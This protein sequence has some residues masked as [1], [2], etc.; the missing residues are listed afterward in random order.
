MKKSYVT[1]GAC[2]LEISCHAFLSVHCS[3]VVSCWERANLL[4]L[5][6]VT[7]FVFLSL[8]HVVSWVRCGTWLYRFLIFA[9]LLTLFPL[10]SFFFQIMFPVPHLCF[11]VLLKIRP[12]FQYSSEIIA[13]VPSQPKTP[14]RASTLI[15]HI[16]HLNKL[17]LTSNLLCGI[18]GLYIE[19]K[20][21]D[22]LLDICS[23]A[24][25]GGCSRYSYSDA[26]DES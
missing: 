13:L 7:F 26:I 2:T 9:L 11:P 8:S 14:Q 5:L 21:G 25:S 4:A 16:S 10:F 23:P 15:S 3:L 17:I 22:R 6:Y 1:S 20:N 19:D 18:Q 12:F 24:P